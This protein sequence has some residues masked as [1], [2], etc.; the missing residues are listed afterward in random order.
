MKK[1][2]YCTLF[3]RGYLPQGLAL[4]RSLERHAPGHRLWVLAL[5]RPTAELL[6]T[7]SLPGLR[8]LLLDDIE[9]PQLRSAKN[10]RSWGEYCWTLTPFLPELVLQHDLDADC[11]IYIDAD[12][13]LWGPAE[14]LLQRFYRSDAA[15]MITPH[16]YSPR[17][18]HA[19]GAGIYCVQFLPFRRSAAALEI[20]HWWQARCLE[21][22]SADLGDGPLGDQ[23]YLDDWPDRFGDQV[24]VLNQPSLTLAPWNIESL[25]QEAL[26][27][28][29]LYHFQGF[30]LFRLARWLVVKASAGVPLPTAMG[31]CLIQPYLADLLAAVSLCP[32]GSLPRRPLLS[33]WRDGRGLLLLLPRLLWFHWW[34]Q[35]QPLPPALD[36]QR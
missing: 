11:A 26:E 36:R 33:L 9:T 24:Y 27:S 17:Q 13:W 5:D 18:N 20:L 21:R 14:Q 2:A 19:T 10:N 34:I 12:C 4:Q 23:G 25:W 29:C 8:V 22:C 30:R 31:H 15:C 32:A 3:D 7:L 16:A 28:P 1:P 35:L 6:E